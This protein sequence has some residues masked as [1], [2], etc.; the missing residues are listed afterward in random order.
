[1]EG[2]APGHVKETPIKKSWLIAAIGIAAAAILIAV[3][4]AVRLQSREAEARQQDETLRTEMAALEEQLEA[5]EAKIQE[6]QGQLDQEAQDNEALQSQLEAAMKEAQEA[7]DALQRKLVAEA[8]ARRNVASA[9]SDLYPDLY[10]Q[11]ADLESL[12]PEK[13]IY[14]TF[15]DGPSDRTAEVLDILKENEE[16]DVKAT[17]FVTGKT[18]EEAQAL[19]RRIVEEG[20][21][22]A[23]HT[24]THKYKTIY[25]SVKAY[26]DD[27]YKIY[28]YIHDVTGVY[29]QIFRF[30]G[31]SNTGYNKR[32]RSQL[33][34]EMDRRG[35]VH[36]DWN[37]LNGDAEGKPYTEEEMK[38]YALRQVGVSHVIMLM[39]DAPDKVKTV[40]CLPDIIAGYRDAGYTFAVLRPEIKSISF[41]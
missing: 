10:A 33:I 1:M 16:N 14:L 25:A 26:L 27:F 2:L 21:T 35:F 6:L 37:A 13:T 40:A 18:G 20:H 28:T 8:E 11:P 24:Y 3:L 9:Y 23:I 22:I 15:D 36:Y 12:A 41:A 5:A 17:F 29:P 4:L 30:P 7:R 39:H 19:M 38:E 34:A 31:G 32:I